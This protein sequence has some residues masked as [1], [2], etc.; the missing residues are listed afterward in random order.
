MPDDVRSF[1]KDCESS[2]SETHNFSGTILMRG[3]LSH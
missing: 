2:W 3:V 1:G